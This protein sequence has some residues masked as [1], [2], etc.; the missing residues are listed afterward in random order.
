AE[1]SRL[2]TQALELVFDEDR[3]R[4][5]EVKRLASQGTAR[6]GVVALLIGDGD[7]PPAWDAAAPLLQA[8]S[9]SHPTDDLTPYLIGR[10]Q[11]LAGRYADA[12][13]YLDHSVSFVAGL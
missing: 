4:T 7:L 9:D 6:E 2:Y 11:L 13:K 10:N 3:R 8:W 12:I 1:A 5:L